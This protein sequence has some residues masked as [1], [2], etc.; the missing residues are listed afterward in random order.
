LCGFGEQVKQGVL[1]WREE[2]GAVAGGTLEGVGGAVGYTGVG[3][4]EALD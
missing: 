2:I 4:P 1:P 3:I